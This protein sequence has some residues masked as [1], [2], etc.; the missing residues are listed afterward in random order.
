[1][2]ADE[3]VWWELARILA[4][5]AGED[6]RERVIDALRERTALVVID[7]VDRLSAP[8]RASLIRAFQDE[9]G[10]TLLM[11]S[12]ERIDAPGIERIDVGPL[13][14]GVLCGAAESMFLEIAGLDPAR[15][16]PNVAKASSEVCAILG[17][18]PLALAAAAG[19]ARLVGVVELHRLLVQS[20]IRALG[21]A[22][23]S[24]GIAIG[25]SLS[26]LAEGDCELLRRLS[27]FA[28]GFNWTSAQEVYPDDRFELLD[29]LERLVEGSL[30]R[31]AEEVGG[32]RFAILDLVRDY[33][34]ATFPSGPATTDRTLALRRHADHY[35]K[36]ARAAA[37]LAREG[38]W[39]DATR[40]IRAEL[41]NFRAALAYASDQGLHE[42]AAPLAECLCRPLMEAGMA[43]DFARFSREGY[44]AAESRGDRR[45]RAD[46]LGLEGALA[47]RSGDAERCA[48]AWISRAALCREMDDIAGLVDATL[49]LAYEARIAKSFGHA[50]D[51]VSDAERSLI[52]LERPDLEATAAAVRAIT[53]LE[54]GRPN[55]ARVSALAAEEKGR[56]ASAAGSMV[57]VW[58]QLGHVWRRLGDAARAETCF[59][60]A[61]SAAMDGDR[62][63]QTALAAL[64]L[65]SVLES[66]ASIEGALLSAIAAETILRQIG[67]RQLGA[68]EHRRS[69]LSERH[70]GHPALRR[71]DRLATTDPLELLREVLE[72]VAARDVPP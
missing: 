40:T 19:R 63:C 18:V 65:S 70:Q 6:H 61:T 60:A 27:V 1:M 35:V 42:V 4:P 43:S 34:A 30:V 44:R 32:T 25:R 56:R 50:F 16:S 15:A 72:R 57:Y 53:E 58:S 51:L 68:A 59:A 28:G 5:R 20:P 52:G 23:S 22:A 33:V 39:I 7:G 47:G 9:T 46:L 49:D 13:A 66:R 29:G 45:L 36:V 48:R 24:V 2:D 17:G 62:L 55:D 41:A 21:G 11:T 64:G 3:D 67:A 69:E 10:A 37:E 54:G 31:R 38:R 14:F 26:L 8:G 12:R 71:A